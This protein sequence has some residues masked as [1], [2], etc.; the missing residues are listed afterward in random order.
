MIYG[1]CTEP[2]DAVALAEAAFLPQLEMCDSGPF[3][4]ALEEGG[5]DGRI[6]IEGK[7]DDVSSRA[8]EALTV[9][10]QAAQAVD[11]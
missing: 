8:A 2:E 5:Y 3:F 1:V 9:L 11:L 10:K 7:W 4:Q 6:S